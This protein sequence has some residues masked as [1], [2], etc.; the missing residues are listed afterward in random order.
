MTHS[1]DLLNRTEKALNALRKERD[2]LFLSVEQRTYIET[3][4]KALLRSKAALSNYLV[5]LQ[6]DNNKEL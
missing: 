6:H 5:Q 1:K 3:E 4:I 2:T